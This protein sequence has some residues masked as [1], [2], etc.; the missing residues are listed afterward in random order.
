[1]AN[2]KYYKVVSNINGKL[3]S[4]KHGFLYTPKK[5]HHR[6]ETEKK[7]SFFVFTTFDAA[8]NFRDGYMSRGEIWECKVID[9]S[10]KDNVLGSISNFKSNAVFC[11]SVMLTKCVDKAKLQLQ[12][13]MIFRIKRTKKYVQYNGWQ[14]S[15]NILGGPKHGEQYQYTNEDTVEG[16]TSRYNLVYCPTAKVKIIAQITL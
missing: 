9:P 2:Q 6:H 15:F 12:E 1:M 14:S 4:L 3:L 8:E 7:T 10:E 5:W 13:G 16:A 11:T